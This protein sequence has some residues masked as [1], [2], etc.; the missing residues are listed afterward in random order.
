[1]EYGGALG[2]VISSVTKSG[3]AQFHGEGHY[4]YSGNAISAGPIQRIQLS[5]TEVNQVTVYHLQDP[6]APLNRHEPGAS[7]GGPIFR[8][9]LFFF[10]SFSPQI[11]RRSNSF[12][13]SNG[14]EPGTI[15]KRETNYQGFGKLTYSSGKI[16][17]NFSTLVTPT[18]DMGKI[19]SY[20]GTGPNYQVS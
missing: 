16:N 13:F 3:G 18:R 14:T 10:G 19:P 17:A 12:L 5:P 8:D 15:T 6:K 20:N 11:V 9:R 1:A 2:G 4:Y 7:L